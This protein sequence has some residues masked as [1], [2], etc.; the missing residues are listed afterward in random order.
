M[1]DT[2]LFVLMAAIVAM[3]GMFLADKNNETASQ[4]TVGAVQS[5]NETP[6][7]IVDINDPLYGR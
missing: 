3:G 2:L 5:H 7:K 1:K 4:N 6:F